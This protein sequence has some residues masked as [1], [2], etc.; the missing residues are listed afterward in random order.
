M[1]SWIREKPHTCM[2]AKKRATLSLLLIYTFL[3]QIL[4]FTDWGF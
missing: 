4:F 2:D 3:K 1:S